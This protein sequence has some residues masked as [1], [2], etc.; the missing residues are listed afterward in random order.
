MEEMTQEMSSNEYR[1]E[2]VLLLGELDRLLEEQ[3][4]VD[5]RDPNA[6][7]ACERKLE[8]VRRRIERL[9]GARERLGSHVM[10]T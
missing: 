5:V 9:T 3:R 7:A 2:V 8:E 1:A 4:I 6:L 10:D